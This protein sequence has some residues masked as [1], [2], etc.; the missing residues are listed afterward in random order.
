MSLLTKNGWNWHLVSMP[1]NGQSARGDVNQRKVRSLPSNH[2]AL[3]RNPSGD[4]SDI[5]TTYRYCGLAHG[6][7][8]FALWN[9][10]APF[11][12]LI[13]TDDDQESD[14]RP[15]VP[16]KFECSWKVDR[17][18]SMLPKML[19]LGVRKSLLPHIGLSIVKYLNPIL[20]IDGPIRTRR[21]DFRKVLAGPFNFQL[22]T[23][24]MPTYWIV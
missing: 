5:S 15:L 2:T 11:G 7:S 12:S 23:R 16:T 18:W 6:D 24:L 10:K 13:R 19:S 22:F 17:R 4:L 9:T 20:R 21:A 14:C 3:S 1:V 8:E